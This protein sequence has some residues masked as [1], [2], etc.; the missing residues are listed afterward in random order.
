MKAHGARCALAAASLV[1]VTGCSLA[2]HYE[3]PEFAAPA[4]YKE[5][6]GDWQP[7]PADDTAPRGEWW[8][9]FADPQ[10][11]SL[12]E[13]LVEGNQD[14]Q[15]ASARY[16]QVRAIAREANAGRLPGIAAGASA[17]RARGSANA[18]RANGP[19][20]VG[21]DYDA[22]LQF[23]WEIDLFGRARNEAAAA[24]RRAQ[25]SSADLGA[26][27]LALGAQLASLYFSVRGAD[28]TLALLDDAEKLYDRALTLTRNRY[29]G[30]IAAATDV[31]Q[32]QTQLQDARAQLAAVRLQRATFEHAIAVLLGLPPAQFSLAVSPSV[33][34]APAI[35]PLLPSA[36]LLRR[37]DIASAEREVAAANAGI[38]VA[39]AAW[40]PVFS[41][42]ASGGY[43]ATSTP[44]WFDAPS[45]YWAVGPSAVFPLLDWGAKSGRVRQAH[46]VFD[47]AVANYRQAVLVAWQ[48]VEDQLAALHHLADEAAAEDAAAASAKSSALHAQRRYEGGIAD[49]VEVTSTQSAA[50]QAQRAAID[51]RVRRL[52]AAVSLLRAL[53][54]DWRSTGQ[55]QAAAR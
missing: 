37:P 39:R 44:A 14:L 3:R 26:V 19:S 50:L 55:A 46:A 17:T 31:D 28:A 35:A 5:L 47:E 25:A 9:T 54:G 15:A 20:A 32:A 13:R 4:T 24:R 42:G 48:E 53:G 10:L 16:A 36:L 43:E 23:A 30:G 29:E 22:G 27:Q 41:L 1:L 51:A 49:Y 38:G 11:D 6:A 8:R 34:E 33:V 52:N 40:F 2:P 18:P 12:E 21:N 45:R 7:A